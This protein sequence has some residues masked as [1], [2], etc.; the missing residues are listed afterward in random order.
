MKYLADGQKVQNSFY[1][2]KPASTDHWTA[3][4]IGNVLDVFHNNLWTAHQ[5]AMVC[6]AT[7]LVEIVAT[8][9]TDLDGLKIARPISP[10]EAGTNASTNLPNNATFALKLSP[11]NRGRGSAGRIFWPTMPRS[12]VTLDSIDPAYIADAVAA[13]G[14]VVIALLALTGSPQL[15][16]VSRYLAGVK[17]AIGLWRAITS[18]GATDNY[19]DSQRDRLPGHKKHKRTP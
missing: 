13:I 2:K 9:L 1:V 15:G 19:V 8:D 6:P 17:R 18:I 3:G 12:A 7:S 14:S 10:T 4:D 16:V 5:R 11:Q